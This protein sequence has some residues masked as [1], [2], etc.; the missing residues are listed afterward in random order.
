ML[1]IGAF[2]RTPVLGV[3]R[4]TD[5]SGTTADVRFFSSI[6]EQFDKTLPLGQLASAEPLPRRTLCWVR[7]DGA[8]RQG[9]IG[10][11][12][13]GRYEVRLSGSGGGYYEGAEIDVP[14]TV[15]ST[16]PV[17]SSAASS[18]PSLRSTYVT[19]P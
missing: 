7:E 1:T 14:R 3:G 2:V 17:S 13:D 8:W 4:V 12:V 18:S 9:Y 19:S 15:S 11:R 10:Q 6:T 16:C 5:V